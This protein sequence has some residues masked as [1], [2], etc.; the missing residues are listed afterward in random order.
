MSIRL[1]K[2]SEERRTQASTFIVFFGARAPQYMSIL[3]SILV[4]ITLIYAQQRHLGLER[5]HLPE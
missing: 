4:E 5:R 3:S 1:A 2:K